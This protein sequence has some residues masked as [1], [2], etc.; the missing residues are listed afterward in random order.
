MRSGYKPGMSIPTPVS[1]RCLPNGRWAVDVLGRTISRHASREAARKAAD[2]WRGD[3][4]AWRK[5][6]AAKRYGKAITNADLD[7]LAER[8]RGASRVAVGGIL[9]VDEARLRA[10]VGGYRTDGLPAGIGYRTKK[11]LE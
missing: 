7:R 2:R 1:T 11:G 8:L 10:I 5:Q 9:Y 3:L 4:V 6:G